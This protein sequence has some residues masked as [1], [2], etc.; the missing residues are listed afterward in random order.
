MKIHNDKLL[1]DP[2][3]V[4]FN[5]IKSVFNYKSLQGVFNSYKLQASKEDRVVGDPVWRKDVGNINVIG[6]RQNPEIAFNEHV[7]HNDLLIISLNI[8]PEISDIYLFSCTM[9]PKGRILKVAHLMEGVYASYNALRPHKWV[10]GRTA[11]VQDRDKVLVGRTNTHG[12]LISIKP[13]KG[14]FGINIHDSGGYQNSSLGCTVLEP[15]S[16]ENNYQYKTLFKPILKDYCTNKNSIDY[17]VIN[18]DTFRYLATIYTPLS[19]LAKGPKHI[20][21]DT[22][23]LSSLCFL[24]KVGIA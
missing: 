11:M 1:K 10:P 7:L 8:E 3:F 15:D 13:E 21:E 24:K 6:V 16:E 17:M 2:R 20:K 19:L 5:S 12:D 4:K 14:F 23:Y 9:D 22:E 18:F